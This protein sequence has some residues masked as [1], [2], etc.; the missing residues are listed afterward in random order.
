MESWLRAMVVV[1]GKMCY[2]I[3]AFKE[4]FFFYNA[5]VHKISVELT[6]L[7]ISIGSEISILS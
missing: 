4:V 6:I 5:E 7:A 3:S 2:K 1:H